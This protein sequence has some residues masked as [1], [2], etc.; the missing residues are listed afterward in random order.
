MRML[1]WTAAFGLYGS[2]SAILCWRQGLPVINPASIM[3]I[4]FWGIP[5]VICASQLIPYEAYLRIS[6]S[7]FEVRDLFREWSCPWTDVVAFQGV[8][9]T[10]TAKQMVV[11]KLR[12][13]SGRLVAAPV[14]SRWLHMWD[15]CLPN[16]YGMSVDDLVRLLN[17]YRMQYGGAQQRAETGE[18]QESW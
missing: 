9:T 16:T 6:S 8:R 17:E 4:I 13:G 2:S 12:P 11:F 15:G 18:A 3:N 14:A 10:G 1:L 5:A 7:G